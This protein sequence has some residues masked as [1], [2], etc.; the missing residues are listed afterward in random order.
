MFWISK[1]K[2]PDYSCR[3]WVIHKIYYPYQ[4]I[5]ACYDKDTNCFIF[6]PKNILFPCSIPLNITHY[7]EIPHLD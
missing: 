6:G 2:T 4:P 1:E 5:E 7:I 3:V